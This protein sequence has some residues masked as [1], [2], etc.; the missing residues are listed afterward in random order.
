MSA[1][2][3]FH[4]APRPFGSVLFIWD[5]H[6]CSS[7][8][9]P[10]RIMMTVGQLALFRFC[11]PLWLMCLSILFV[12]ALRHLHSWVIAAQYLSLSTVV[13]PADKG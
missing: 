9:V 12:F 7:Y 8:C 2:P 3:T 10:L 5:S 11:C 13:P 6:I 4:L 1:T